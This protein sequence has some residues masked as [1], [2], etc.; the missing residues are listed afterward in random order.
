MY[1]CKDVKQAAYYPCI[2]KFG[3]GLTVC[4]LDDKLVKGQKRAARFETRT[5]NYGTGK[6]TG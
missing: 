6:T 4:D 2:L 3:L 1:A 5:Y